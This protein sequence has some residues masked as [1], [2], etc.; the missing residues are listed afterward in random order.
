MYNVQFITNIVGDDKIKVPRENSLLTMFQFI[1][2][3]FLTHLFSQKHIIKIIGGRQDGSQQVEVSEWKSIARWR[4]A[5][6]VSFCVRKW[7]NLCI[8][9]IFV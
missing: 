8:N 7:G 6:M 4:F 5:S 1:S 9:N 2:E 3:Y